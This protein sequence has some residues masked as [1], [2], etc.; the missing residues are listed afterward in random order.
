MPDWVPGIGGKKFGFSIDPI[1]I[2]RLA[3]G[4][5]IPPNRE[6]LAVLG[7]QKSGTNIEAPADLIRQIVAE[8]LSRRDPSGGAVTI[9]FT[10][11]LAQLARVLKPQLDKEAARKGTKLVIGGAH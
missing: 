8:E 5:V 9:N 3:R 1:S 2:P 10:G 7:D 4:A 6:F 11:N